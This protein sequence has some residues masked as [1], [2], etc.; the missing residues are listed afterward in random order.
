QDLPDFRGMFFSSFERMG[1]PVAAPLE[2]AR[3]LVWGA[4][5]YARTLGFKPHPDFEPAAGHL[6][7]PWEE[8]SAITFGRD[9][10][11]FYVSGPYD[12]PNTVLGTLAGSVGRGGFDHVTAVNQ[13][14]VEHA[15]VGG[16]LFAFERMFDY[17]ECALGRSGDAWCTRSA[18]LRSARCRTGTTGNGRRWWPCCVPDPPG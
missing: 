9:G 18:P 10:V 2:M 5:D 1:E 7:E 3:H 11:P 15:A 12:N 17:T 6:G 14:S 8:T 16:A 4:V 13:R